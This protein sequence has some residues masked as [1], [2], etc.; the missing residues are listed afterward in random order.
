MTERPTKLKHLFRFIAF[1]MC[2][3][4][5]AWYIVQIARL[6]LTHW[7]HMLK[8]YIRLW[9]YRAARLPGIAH[10]IVFYRFTDAWFDRHFIAH[11]AA[12]T[13]ECWLI[14]AGFVWLVNAAHKLTPG[15][16]VWL[17]TFG[18]IVYLGIMASQ[19]WFHLH[20]SEEDEGDISMLNIGTAI[21]Q[22]Q[23]AYTHRREE[24]ETNAVNARCFVT[25]EVE[26]SLFPGKEQGKYRVMLSPTD[27][28]STMDTWTS[29]DM[30]VDEILDSL[31]IAPNAAI[32]EIE[33]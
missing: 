5:Y 15:F 21:Q 6:F 29:E 7:L 9:A 11:L 13:L 28:D 24:S 26:V 33:G 19:V 23:N 14:M 31:Q 30:P 3:P 32:W 22:L 25:L 27:D 17:F 1:M 2:I 20:P 4:S 8:G 12:F 10:M 18:T 16:V